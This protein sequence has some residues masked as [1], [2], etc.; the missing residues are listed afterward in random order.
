MDTFSPTN[1]LRRV[2]LPTFGR[3]MMAT[4]PVRGTAAAGPSGTSAFTIAACP[5]QP[6]PRRLC[7]SRRQRGP[8]RTKA[9]TAGRGTKSP[10]KGSS[11]YRR[12]R[13]PATFHLAFS[14]AQEISEAQCFGNVGQGLLLDQIGA[15]ARQIALIQTCI[16]L[17]QQLGN[18][19][20][21]NSI[22]K[23][24]QPLVVDGAVTAVRHTLLQKVRCAERVAEAFLK[25]GQI[26]GTRH[27]FTTASSRQ[28]RQRRQLPALPGRAPDPNPNLGFS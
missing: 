2:D 12:P 10:P 21:E 5:R 18:R 1:A 26:H 7:R 14:Q 4:E 11:N 19:A 3:P 23:K 24:L 16:F 13:K 9:A 15:Q 27:P 28:R 8:P 20:I 22:A 17:E 25:R 6:A